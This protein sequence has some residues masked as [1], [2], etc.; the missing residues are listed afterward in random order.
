MSISSDELAFA[1]I[2]TIVV[3][4]VVEIAILK[5]VDAFTVRL[6]VFPVSFVYRPSFLIREFAVSVCSVVYEKPVH[7]GAVREHEISL[8]IFAFVPFAYVD[9]ASFA[10]FSL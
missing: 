3:S 7:L 1:V 8:S 10:L 6:V 2:V 4:A 9:Y 5:F